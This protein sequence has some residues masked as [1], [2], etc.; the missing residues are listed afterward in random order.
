MNINQNLTE[1]D[2]NNTDV[3]SQLEHQIQIQ[4]TK[5]SGWIFDKTSSMKLGFY[6]TGELN[7]SNCIKILFRSN[8]ILQIENKDEY[9]FSWSILACVLSCKR[10][11]PNRVSNYRLYF[12]ELSIEGFDFSSGFRCS[13]VHIFE[14]LNNSSKNKFELNFYQKQN[15]WKRNLSPIE[16]S[17]NDPDKVIDLLRY[18]NQYVLIKKLNELSGKF[19]KNF[20]C[21]RCLISHTSEKINMIHKPKSWN[22]GITK[23]RTSPESHL[24][25]KDHFHKNPIKFRIIA[26]FEADN[27]NYIFNIRNKKPLFI[28]KILCVMGNIQNLK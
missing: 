22:N 9:C 15:N 26:H 25:S 21:K 12:D 10:D 18:K 7:E 13:D 11:H 4:E 23:I 16:I 3:K 1:S 28:N 2:I 24:H 6:K 17:K 27:E 19:N 5:E 14:K 20:I 8:A